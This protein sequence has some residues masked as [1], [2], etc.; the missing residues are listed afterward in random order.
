MFLPHAVLLSEP[1]KKHLTVSENLQRAVFRDREVQ[2]PPLIAEETS[3][4]NLSPPLNER[5]TARIG[6]N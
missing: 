2:S 3:G 5:H 4:G 1:D 6:L